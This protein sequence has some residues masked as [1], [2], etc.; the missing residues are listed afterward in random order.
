MLK[1]EFEVSIHARVERA[2]MAANKWKRFDLVSIH[3]RVERAT[4][5]VAA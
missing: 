3:A 5:V 4:F 2:T 1:T